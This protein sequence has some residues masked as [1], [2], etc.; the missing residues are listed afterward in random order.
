VASVVVEAV[1]VEASAVA[2]EASVEAVAAEAALEVV[3]E[4]LWAPLKVLLKSVFSLTSAR[5]K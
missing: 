1:A 2:E 3:S 4:L 5:T